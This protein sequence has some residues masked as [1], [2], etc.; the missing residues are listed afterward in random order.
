M[1]FF[2]FMSFNRNKKIAQNLRFVPQMF[3]HATPVPCTDREQA[4]S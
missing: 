2:T 3:P 4:K 1:R